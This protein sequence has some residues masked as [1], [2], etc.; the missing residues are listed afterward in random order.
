VSE[1]PYESPKADISAADR[2]S[3]VADLEQLASDYFTVNVNLRVSFLNHLVITLFILVGAPPQWT[4]SMVALFGL[5]TLINGYC[6]MWIAP[7]LYS[8]LL[9]VPLPVMAVI[10]GIGLLTFFLFRRRAIALLEDQRVTAGTLSVDADS[11][12]RRIQELLNQQATR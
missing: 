8:A 9:G 1:N 7:R 3:E 10:P 2:G 4:A 5:A 12:A 11:L 6:A